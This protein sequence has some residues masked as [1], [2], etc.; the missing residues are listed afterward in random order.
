MGYD[1]D[2]VDGGSRAEDGLEDRKGQSGE[3]AQQQPGPGGEGPT[4]EAWR[5]FAVDPTRA[6]KCRVEAVGVLGVEA[7][8]QALEPAKGILAEGE[9]VIPPALE[10][11][12]LEELAQAGEGEMEEM[13]RGV[14]MEPTRTGEASLPTRKVGHGHDEAAAGLQDSPA[15]LESF[16]G[17]A[18]VFEHMPDH[19]LVEAVFLVARLD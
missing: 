16:E 6:L 19:D 1:R 5:A 18:K 13:P 8:L 17:L 3:G 12:A 11:A 10:T 4:E 2:D 7:I 15:L 9:M 14:E